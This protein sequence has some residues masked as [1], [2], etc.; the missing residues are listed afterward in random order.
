MADLP[1][2][3]RD[4]DYEDEQEDLEPLTGYRLVRVIIFETVMVAIVGLL[5]LGLA[6][7]LGFY[8]LGMVLA[9]VIWV[10]ISPAIEIAT[11]NRARRNEHREREE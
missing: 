7:E 11:V 2:D 5:V 1:I 6:A 3:G 10:G 8:K 9:I 4:L